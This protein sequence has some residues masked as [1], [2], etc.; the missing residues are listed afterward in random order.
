MM[1][2]NKRK[3]KDTDGTENTALFSGSSQRGK[4]VKSGKAA[5]PFPVHPFQTAEA[6]GGGTGE[7][8]L[9]PAQFFHGTDRGRET[10]KEAGSG[11]DLHG[12]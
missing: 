5:A 10:F 4:Y 3:R 1:K 9:Y 7:K 12:R 8:T 6:D 11:S 2:Q